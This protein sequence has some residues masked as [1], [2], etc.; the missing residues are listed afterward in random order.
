MKFLVKYSG[1]CYEIY[2]NCTHYIDGQ[3]FLVRSGYKI[4]KINYI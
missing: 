3:T 1:S 2:V 4:I